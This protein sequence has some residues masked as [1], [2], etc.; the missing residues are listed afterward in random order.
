MYLDGR[1]I[2]VVVNE[3]ERRER[4]VRILAD[5][6]FAVTA[7]SEGLAA[8]REIGARRYSLVVAGVDLPGSL[9]GPTTVRRARRRQPWL[10]ALY[11][12]QLTNRPPLGDPDA[13][14]FIAAPFERWELLGCTFELLHRAAGPEAAHLARSMRSELRAS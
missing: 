8:L 2:L 14:D 1:E 11:T 12:A 3:P 13:D 7:S 6:G 4:I 5:E 9:D 10:K